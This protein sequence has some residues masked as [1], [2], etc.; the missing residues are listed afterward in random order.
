LSNGGYGVR[1]SNYSHYNKV[2]NATALGRNT[3]SGNTGY[4]VFIGTSNSSEVYGNYIGTDATGTSG[5]PNTLSGIWV[6]NAYL[7]RI[8]NGTTNGINII[9]GNSG[10]GIRMTKANNNAINK[11]YI[12]VGQNG[13]TSLRNDGAGIYYDLQGTG[14]FANNNDI[15]NNIIANNGSTESFYGIQVTYGTVTYETFSQN[16]IYANS[17]GGIYLANGANDSIAT[18]VIS[19]T[20]YETSSW[21]ITG[22]SRDQAVIEIF[23][24]EA[25]H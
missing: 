12:G 18:P 9:S 21:V 23:S 13:T 19:T 1:I 6:H 22:T 5:I 11:N 17:G 14:N 25:K 16:S 3:I 2:G 4:G 8:G 15:T 20:S 7:S 10:H 24:A